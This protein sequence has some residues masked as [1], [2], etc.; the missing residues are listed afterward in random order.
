MVSILKLSQNVMTE[1]VKY[2][3]YKRQNLAFPVNSVFLIGLHVLPVS[4]QLSGFLYQLS[5]TI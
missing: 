4:N 5:G 2:F 3:V 1:I